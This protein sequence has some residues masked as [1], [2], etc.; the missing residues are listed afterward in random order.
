MKFGAHVLIGP[1]GGYLWGFIFAAF[2]MG[3][4]RDKGFTNSPMNYF[5]A[6]FLSTTSIL[7]IGTLYLTVLT[8]DFSNALAMGF[9]PFL[10]GDVIKSLICT[11]ILLGY[12][13]ISF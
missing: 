8:S 6:C 13:K 1:T 9:Y 4:L 2:C 7:I 3:Y 12:R 5:I 10:V 11:V